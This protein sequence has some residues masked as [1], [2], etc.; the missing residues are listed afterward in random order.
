MAA[1]RTP[2]RLNYLSAEALALAVTAEASI[3]VRT[4]GPLLRG[5]CNALQVEYRVVDAP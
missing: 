1:L 2:R 5:A 3:V 4:D